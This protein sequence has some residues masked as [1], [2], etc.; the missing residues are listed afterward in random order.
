MD[1]ELDLERIGS[2][3]Q[4]KLLA[5][6]KRLTGPL[7]DTGSAG[8]GSPVERAPSFCDGP[9]QG[10]EGM[11]CSDPKNCVVLAKVSSNTFAVLETEFKTA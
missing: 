4:Q 1:G 2:G 9:L 6:L 10:A 7:P 3:S 5:G 8:S 11:P